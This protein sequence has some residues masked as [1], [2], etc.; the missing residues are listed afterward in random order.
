MLTFNTKARQDYRSRLDIIRNPDVNHMSRTRVKTERRTA[1]KEKGP[2]NNGSDVTSKIRRKAK[3][4]D[5][6]YVA[7]PRRQV[8]SGFELARRL[9]NHIHNFAIDMDLTSLYPTI[10]LLLNLS[11]KTFVGKLMF[12]K[13]IVPPLYPYIKFIDKKEKSEYK[14]KGDDYFFE[15][16]VGHHWWAMMEIFFNMKTTDQ[17][18]SYIEEHDTEFRQGA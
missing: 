4:Y 10:M 15:C 16:Y 1:S 9:M 11:P 7:E 6:A 8:S 12:Q 13:P 17:I 14:C 2:S 5:G 18:I 3:A